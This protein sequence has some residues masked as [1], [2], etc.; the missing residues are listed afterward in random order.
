MNLRACGKRSLKR[1]IRE[2]EQG[3]ENKAPEALPIGPRR[4]SN[5]KVNILEDREE[6]LGATRMWRSIIWMGHIG[7]SKYTIGLA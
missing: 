3:L 2:L 1:N 4:H 7:R 6:F 5:I